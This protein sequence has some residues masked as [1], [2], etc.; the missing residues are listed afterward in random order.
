MKNVFIAYSGF[1]NC[2]PDH[3]YGPA[4]R[5]VFLLHY[6]L[7]G[8]GVFSF[9]GKRFELGAGEGF[10]I[11]PGEV[12]SYQADGDDP[13]TYFW[14]GAGR[15]DETERALRNHGLGD[16]SGVFLF[17]KDRE[18]IR[19]AQKLLRADPA[20]RNSQNNWDFESSV[21]LFFLAIQSLPRVVSKP[22]STNEMIQKAKFFM[23]ERFAA[24]LTVEE[25]AKHLNVSRS[26]L[27][28]I[29]MKETQK[30]PQRAI[31][32]FKLD[33]ARRMIESGE[34]TLTQ[35]ALSCGFCDLSHF[36]KAYKAY[37]ERYDI[38]ES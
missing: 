12:T 38:T 36:Y 7:S 26:G 22:A 20:I 17:Y 19:T 28:K 27:Y 6:V 18:E 14:T 4:I 32:D 16:S 34:F 5:E 35:I 37:R 8:R 33:K 31:I 1:H 15:T 11:C 30:S 25:M 3:K 10:F 9:R 23:E 21:A 13:W 2:P 29:F 24:N